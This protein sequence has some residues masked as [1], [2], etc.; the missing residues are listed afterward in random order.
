LE[1]S[2]GLIEDGGQFVDFNGAVE[3][4]DASKVV[5]FLD[6]VEFSAE[7]F[8]LLSDGFSEVDFESKV[9]EVG[10]ITDGDEKLGG[11]VVEAVVES[12][13]VIFIN[14]SNT[15][16]VLITNVGLNG[17]ID[18]GGEEGTG[19]TEEQVR[20]ISLL[21]HR[22]ILERPRKVNEIGKIGLLG[23][24][25]LVFTE[26]R[27]DEFEDLDTFSVS[28]ADEVSETSIIEEGEQARQGLGEDLESLE[29]D[30]FDDLQSSGEVG[31][32]DV[33]SQEGDN[34]EITKVLSGSDVGNGDVFE[35]VLS[36]LHDTTLGDE[37]LEDFS[38]LFKTPDVFQVVQEDFKVG[39]IRLH[40]GAILAEGLELVDEFIQYIPDPRS[41]QDNIILSVKE[42]FKKINIVGKRFYTD[43]RLNVGDSSIDM[44]EA[45]FVVEEDS[46]HVEFEVFIIFFNFFDSGPG[47]IDK[48]VFRDFIEFSIIEIEQVVF[49]LFLQSSLKINNESSG[50]F[51]RGLVFQ[52]SIILKI[53]IL[54]ETEVGEIFR[55]DGKFYFFKSRDSNVHW[56]YI[57]I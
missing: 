16:S 33:K 21:D 17:F 53:S 34:T 22:I 13:D 18:G 23:V 29:V 32:E 31:A 37:V 10:S 47:G 26:A 11:A 56:K 9:L 15:I 19:N 57:E 3:L 2:G 8:S 42:G 43:I 27:E 48:G 41:R 38:D 1:L 12:V 46:V 54:R 44:S 24:E 28:L 14:L 55:V 35:F 40:L 39:V 51:H 20:F 4:E 25:L 50:D 52:D 49:F 45:E 6:V 7:S 5:Q 36:S 30:G